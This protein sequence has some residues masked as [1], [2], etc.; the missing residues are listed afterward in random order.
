[1]IVEPAPAKVNLFLHVG[2]R[3]DDGYHPLQS[4]AVFTD[5]GDSLA[6]G[7][8]RELRLKIDGPF[9]S[10]LSA[11][12]DNLVL[13]S[14]H[15]LTPQGAELILTKNLPIASGLGGGSADAAA[16]L[17]GLSVF[18]QRNKTKSELE[19]IAA[20]L[21]SDVPVCLDSVPAFMQ[22]RGEQ[23]Q[24]LTYL[25]RISMLLVNPGVGV[26]TA[27]VFGALKNRSGI[28]MKLPK[29]GF[30]D[31]ADLL[32]FLDATHNDLESPAREIQ[33]LIGEVLN[34]LA[35]LAGALLSRMSGSGATCFA[36]FADDDC[37]QRAAR[38]L[39]QRHPDWWIAPTFVAERGIMREPAGR[40]FGPTPNGI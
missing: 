23:L 5:I 26:S 9:G 10:N 39:R 32:R 30:R 20:S 33:P 24:P 37:C 15:A 1:M 2:E 4:L 27:D 28:T 29:E 19:E 36:I 14:A 16:A 12:A 34:S 17:R 7:P 6:I 35:C 22:G 3:R 25:P 11:G 8:A 31:T 18:W 40:D 38:S 21:G 13:K